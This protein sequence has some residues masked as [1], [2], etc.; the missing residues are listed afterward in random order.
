[1]AARLFPKTHI[2]MDPGTA[3]T[4]GGFGWVP[5]YHIT[6]QIQTAEGSEGLA[7]QVIGK[8]E[9]FL[10]R[11]VCYTPTKPHNRLP[12]AS[13]TCVAAVCTRVRR[14]AGWRTVTDYV[15]KWHAS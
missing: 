5:S 14:A 13:P 12:V 9:G 8:L 6:E 2:D 10:H 1:M 11:Q 15:Y 4:P 7:C 3:N